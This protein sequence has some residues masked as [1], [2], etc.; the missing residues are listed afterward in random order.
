MNWHLEVIAAKLTAVQQGEIR[1]LIINLPPRHLKSIVFSVALPAF[2]LGRD[3][4]NRIICVSYSS[5]LAVKH[6]ND[7][8]AVM[9][10]E[11]YR[12]VFPATKISREK[13]TQY[14][15]MTTARGYR[16]ATSL[17]GTLTGR[18]ADLIVLDDP[19]KPDEALSETHR[20]S[21]GQWFDTTLL[22]RLD[23]KS[24][25]AVVIV[26]QRLH[27]DDLAG[28]LLEKGGWP[29]LK[30]PAIAE[31]EE[32][33]PIGL[34]RIYRR[35]AGTVIDPRRES[36]K[37]LERLK[38]QMTEL[39]FSAQYQQEPIPLAGNII[40]AEWFKEYEITPAYSNN[41]LL[42]ISL[43]TAM[44]G[45]QLADYSVATVW[46]ARGDHSYLLDLWRERV[47]YPELRR[48]VWRLREKYAGAALL[49]EDKGSGTSLI[50]DL[51]AENR[52]VIGINPEGDKLTRAA[53]TS[54]Q[55]EAGAVFFPK[56]APWLSGL[57]AELLGFPNVRYDDQVDSVTQALSW[58]SQRRQKQIPFVAPIIISRPRTYFGDMPPDYL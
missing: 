4:T 31:Q 15:T 2:L 23:S 42:I 56:A 24:D 9:T 33:I 58:I 54:A 50:Q 36:L 14:E 55:F 22:S 35:K 48:A 49:V 21:A 46:L 51:R 32:R 5:E 47:D 43:D 40:K 57:K 10:A 19:Q 44:K 52:A 6:A 20:N 29:H 8:R 18:G 38:Q 1:R 37:D 25:G 26:M 30:I 45:T 12:R 41:D 13:D 28:R 17:H 3:P 27:E 11:W 16:Y 34:G 53:K 7:F 39:F